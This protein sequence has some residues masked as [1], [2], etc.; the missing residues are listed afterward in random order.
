[1]YFQM[2]PHCENILTSKGRCRRS[3]RTLKNPLT[4]YKQIP[5]NPG[6]P[7]GPA[8][9]Y[10]IG[11]SC[12]SC[13][14][15]CDFC[16]LSICHCSLL[17]LVI[18][19]RQTERQRPPRPA[20][21]QMTRKS[22]MTFVMNNTAI[23]IAPQFV[24]TWNYFQFPLSFA[25]SLISIQ[26]TKNVSGRELVGKVFV[27]GRVETAATSVTLLNK[28]ILRFSPNILVQTHSTNTFKR[29]LVQLLKC[30]E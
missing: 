23:N 3:W 7:L 30:S 12:D 15:K 19:W 1:M 25:I 8:H 13:Q 2:Y 22:T 29:R 17:S 10:F 16:L 20:D 11:D 24:K 18:S 21:Q 26:I 5:K 14:S 28:E 9:H 27:T 4:L 6:I